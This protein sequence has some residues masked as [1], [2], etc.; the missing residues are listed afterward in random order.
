MPRSHRLRRDARS[1]PAQPHAHD[2]SRIWSRSEADWQSTQPPTRNDHGTDLRWVVL[3]LINETAR[4]AGHADVTRE[5]LDGA[6]GD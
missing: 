4:H 1:L 6:T 2:D 5:L 3:H